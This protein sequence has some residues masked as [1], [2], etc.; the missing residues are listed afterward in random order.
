MWKIAKF[1]KMDDQVSNMTQ[2]VSTLGDSVFLLKEEDFKC[3]HVF[4]KVS[5]HVIRRFE[6][7]KVSTHVHK[8]STPETQK[9]S[10][11][12]GSI[13]ECRVL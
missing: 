11:P 7:S 1:F 10:T 8:V 2:K 4:C 3:R 9:V 5:I 6:P 12:N 13:F